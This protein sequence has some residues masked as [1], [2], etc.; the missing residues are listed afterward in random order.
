MA[1]TTLQ[2]A[3]V[4][5]FQGCGH[6]V[7]RKGECGDRPCPR[8]AGQDLA[9]HASLADHTSVL[10]AAFTDPM[11]DAAPP[12]ALASD[13]TRPVTAAEFSDAI[14]AGY[15]DDDGDRRAVIDAAAALERRLR[16]V[17]TADLIDAAWADTDLAA[18]LD[19]GP[20]DG[21]TGTW[22]RTGWGR[23]THHAGSRPAP[24]SD[25]A[26][27]FDPADPGDLRRMSRQLRHDA[28]HRLV[29]LWAVDPTGH[30]QTRAMQRIAA[31]TI[32]RGGRGFEPD[33]ALT[34]R[35]KVYAETLKATYDATQE[36]LAERGIG[37]VTLHRGES[38]TSAGYRRHPLASWTSEDWVADWH[39][40]NSTATSGRPGT[41]RVVTADI[42]ARDILSLPVTGMG[43]MTEYEAVV[44]TRPRPDRAATHGLA[45]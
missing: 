39:A 30:P 35:D 32:S 7:R 24:P 8:N 34:G 41:E 15:T 17:P 11:A 20:G 19:G 27:T 43:T 9:R 31:D 16:H 13:G 45:A 22:S 28:A 29:Q 12:S 42:P 37:W 18:D 33:P 3:Q 40:T 25:D 1:H 10:T 26:Q 4:C 21:T 14:T 23:W 5:G 36:W 2:R 6:L 38:A 44:L